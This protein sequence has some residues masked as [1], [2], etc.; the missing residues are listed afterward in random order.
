M[1]SI[2]VEDITKGDVTNYL[3]HLQKKGLNNATRSHYLLVLKHY[4]NYQIN[5]GIRES[6]MIEHIKLRGTH[7]KKLLPILNKQELEII[8]TN[9]QV[10]NKADKNNNR[11]WFT[12][13]RLCKE[14]NK[15]II[16]LL[17]YQGLKTSEINTITIQDVKLKEGKINIPGSRKSNE[18]TLELKPQQIIELMEYIYT[19]RK[20]LLEFTKDKNDYLFLATP[21]SGKKEIQNQTTERKR[22]RVEVR[23]KERGII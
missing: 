3:Q 6:N 9:Y 12:T 11:N 10:P 8:Y 2:E 16:A 18:R 14:R 22:A 4:M 5:L 20:E 17:I 19:T 21:P 13:Y 7:T 23:T 15:I 1:Q